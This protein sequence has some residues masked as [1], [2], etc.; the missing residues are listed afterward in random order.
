MEAQTNPWR[1]KT[2]LSKHA[3]LF[4]ALLEQHAHFNFSKSAVTAKNWGQKFLQDRIAKQ[5]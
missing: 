4:K 1:K 3:I 2:S 5:D